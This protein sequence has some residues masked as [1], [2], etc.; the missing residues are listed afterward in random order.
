MAFRLS[1]RARFIAALLLSTALLSAGFYVAVAQFIEVLEQELGAE[2]LQR[3]LEEFVDTYR[4]DPA[5]P[6][7]SVG[8]LQGYVLRP[9]ETG[10]LPEEV[11]RVAD[12][13]SGELRVGGKD[14]DVGR[15]DVGEMRL[16]L[17]HDVTPVDELEKRLQGLA[18]I[19]ILIAL[20]IASAIGS[21]LSLVV[22][23]PVSMLSQLLS[24]LDPSNRGQRLQQYFIDDDIGTIARAFDRYLQRLDDFVVREQSFTDDASH[25]LRTP[26]AII[27]SGTQLLCEQPGLDARS[28]ARV[29]RI[30][31]AAERMKSLIDALLYLAREDGGL[32]KPWCALDELLPEIIDGVRETA[33]ERAGDLVCTIVA[34]QTVAAPPGMIYVVVR[35]LLDNAIQHSRSG[36]IELRLEQGHV[37]VQDRGA[38]IGADELEHVFERRYRGLRSQGMGLGLYLVEQICRRLS[39]TISVSSAPGSGTRFDIAFA[40]PPQTAG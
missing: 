23:R 15:R 13:G 3:F 16:F 8:D 37:I 28:L 9:G 33:G 2:V 27:L 31:R 29:E 30:Q 25:E 36:S 34:A 38:G 40:E 19:F 35:N 12:G 26:L 21:W 20:A 4:R 1:L 39:W 32:P 22:T 24:T 5:I 17:L 6:P 11:L 14:Y 18:A 7:P 10:G